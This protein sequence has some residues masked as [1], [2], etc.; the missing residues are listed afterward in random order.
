MSDYPDYPVLSRYIRDRESEVSPQDLA[1]VILTQR[2]LNIIK[3]YP[4]IL[5]ESLAI[6]KEVQC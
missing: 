3:Q 4:G 6:M 1:V 2:P 5:I